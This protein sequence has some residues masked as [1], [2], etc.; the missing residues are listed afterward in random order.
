MLHVM[1]S[2]RTGLAVASWSI[3]AAARSRTWTLA[4]T[5]TLT[6]R[7]WLQRRICKLFMLERVWHT[8]L[9][10]VGRSFH[11]VTERP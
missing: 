5:S 1:A 11:S 2:Q 9:A 10:H 7:Q 4:S 8:A 3:L 6:L